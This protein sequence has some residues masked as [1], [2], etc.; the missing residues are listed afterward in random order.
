M[1][2]PAGEGGLGWGMGEGPAGGGAGLGEESISS[3]FCRGYQGELYRGQEPTL[4]G[5][6]RTRGSGLRKQMA[7]PEQGF[8]ETERTQICRVTSTS[9]SK[10]RVCPHQPAPPSILC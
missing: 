3:L 10:D 6:H 7:H 9:L 2:V 8:R 1:R 5:T 4:L